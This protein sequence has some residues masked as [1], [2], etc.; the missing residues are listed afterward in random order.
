M[1]A[2]HPLLATVAVPGLACGVGPETGSEPAT[3][4][5]SA[6]P[7][8]AAPAVPERASPTGPSSD[9]ADW[10]G[11][12]ADDT[13][14]KLPD[15]EKLSRLPKGAGRVDRT[16]ARLVRWRDPAPGADVAMDVTPSTRGRVRVRDES[17]PS[18]REAAPTVCVELRF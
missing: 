18:E 1:R 17:G 2:I 13:G 7:P 9:L 10:D 4:N 16:S 11:S 6:P 8:I 14:T 3:P 5:V 15:L 12:P